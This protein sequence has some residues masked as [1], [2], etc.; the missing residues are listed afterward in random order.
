MTGKGSRRR[1]DN[2]LRGAYQ[3]M[4]RQ[5]RARCVA[6]GR[7]CFFGDGPID[8]TLEHP[9]P[10]SFTVHH[11]VAVASRPDLEME[12]ALWAPAHSICNKAGMAAYD[13]DGGG[14]F[15]AP[16]EE[17]DGYGIPSEPWMSE[18]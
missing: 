12:T 14:V 18:N 16:G 17:N 1:T 4:R 2:E 11:T 6:E 15:V 10:G 8:Y 5:F 7:E 3:V 13:P 9:H